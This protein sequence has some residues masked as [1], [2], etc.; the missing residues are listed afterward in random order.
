MS[1]SENAKRK[2]KAEKISSKEA[3]YL[4]LPWTCKHYPD[5]S[6]IEAYLPG[7]DW[8]TIVEIPANPGI[9]AELVAEFIARTVNGTQKT[10]D[11][12]SQVADALE[13]CLASGNLTWEAEQEANIVLKRIKEGHSKG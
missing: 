8:E 13:L 5:R 1:K 4:M 9:D 2:P 7:R 12:F 3:A 6:E 11:L 10:R